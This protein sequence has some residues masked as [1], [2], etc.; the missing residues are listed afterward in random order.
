MKLRGRAPGFARRR[1]SAS[2]ARTHASTSVLDTA[3]SGSEIEV[4]ELVEGAALPAGVLEAREQWPPGGLMSAALVIDQG[5]EVTGAREDPGRVRRGD[6]LLELTQP[7]DRDLPLAGVER[8]QD[9]VD[10]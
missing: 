4:L 3:S 7:P 9:A 8:E 2:S 6:E 10:V 1:E 5:P